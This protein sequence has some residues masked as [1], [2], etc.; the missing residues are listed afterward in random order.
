MRGPGGRR[1][2][3]APPLRRNESAGC[4]GSAALYSP[5]CWMV[6]LAWPS[7]GRT[8]EPP[9]ARG[10]LTAMLTVD[11][12][13]SSLPRVQVTRGHADCMRFL[14]A[15]GLTRGLLDAG[16][17]VVTGFARDPQRQATCER[18][19]RP[20]KFDLPAIRDLCP[21]AMALPPPAVRHGE[22]LL[23]ACATC[24]PF[25]AQ[26]KKSIGSHGEAVLLGE[27]GRLVAT[28]LPAYVLVEHV[29][30]IARVPS[31]ST[32]R[33]FCRTLDCHRY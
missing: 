6:R 21:A 4:P 1:R 19:N 17:E 28:I 25:G 24:Q 7:R 2:R 32:F 18:N 30:G 20:A 11:V 15:G 10:R 8:C 31:F 12:A 14:I 13:R 9:P 23:A 29:P 22:F 5:C 3:R 27:F 26:R 33:R 16:I